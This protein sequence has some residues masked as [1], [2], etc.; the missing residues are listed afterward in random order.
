[1]V[2]RQML[3]TASVIIAIIA[4]YYDVL[5]LTAIMTIV[6]AAVTPTINKDLGDD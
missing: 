2:V 4:A 6:S 3:F 1:M 5:W